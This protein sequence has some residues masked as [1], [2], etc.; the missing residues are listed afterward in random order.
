MRTK[1]YFLLL[2]CFA[3]ISSIAQTKLIAH[4]SH[5]GN[6]RNFKL[7]LKS[8]N[9]GLKH[10]NFG[11][12]SLDDHVKS[13]T[14]LPKKRVVVYMIYYLRGTKKIWEKRR[15]T[16]TLKE[17]KVKQVNAKKIKVAI[18]Q[19]YHPDNPLKSIEFF[20]LRKSKQIPKIKQ[21]NDSKM[22]IKA[23]KLTPPPAKKKSSSKQGK[24]QDTHKSK[25]PVLTPDADDQVP[26]YDP[27]LWLLVSAMA[28]ITALVG[29]I[30]WR[31][32]KLTSLQTT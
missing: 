6:M 25:V 22:K 19:R 7:A 10:A 18:K 12:P 8:D 20:D 21:K 16:I 13:V 17:L 14:L 5:S 30:A 28:G 29:G 9:F 31:L 26:P 4:K 24:S 15:D 23:P 32:R 11:L 1:V 27:L 2:L 3:S